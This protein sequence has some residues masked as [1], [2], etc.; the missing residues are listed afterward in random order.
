VPLN[1]AG[2][3]QAERCAAYLQQS[4][5]S[6]VVTSPLLR[7][8]QTA[9]VIAERLGLPPPQPAAAFVERDYGAASGKTNAE[10]AAL[11]PDGQVPGTEPRE[12]MR[13][14]AMA[15]LVELA[16]RYPGERLVVVAH[17]GVIN[18]ILAELS[19]GAIGSGKTTLANACISI[20]HLR[21]DEWQI[22]VFNL[23]AHLAPDDA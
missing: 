17:G 21:G 15:G 20:V 11:F 7:A 3:R 22:E 8:Q 23:V 6:R 18:A 10:V 1:A 19:A 14:R 5:W 13:R 12:A 2:Y 16:R 4:A 9:A